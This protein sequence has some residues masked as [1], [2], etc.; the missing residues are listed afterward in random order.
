MA[1]LKSVFLAS[2]NDPKTVTIVVLRNQGTEVLIGR[3]GP[4]RGA[5]TWVLPG[6]HV[7]V[8]ESDQDAARRELLEEAGFEPMN[9]VPVVRY[10]RDVVFMTQER[11]VEARPGG[12]I[13]IVRWVRVNKIPDLAYV[14]NRY[15]TA[16]LER[17]SPYE[18]I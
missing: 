11:E 13:E 17:L 18:V 5:G 1:N 8:G 6:G 9:L 15:V 4:G 12:D 7:E 2:R 16:A 3:K 10:E 14:H